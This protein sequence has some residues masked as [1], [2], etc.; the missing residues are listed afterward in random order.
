MPD[1]EDRSLI[2]VAGGSLSNAAGSKGIMSA[3][4][5]ETLAITREALAM[6]ARRFKIGRYEWCEPEYRQILIWAKD[7]GMEPETLVERL[8]YDE[9]KSESAFANFL[10]PPRGSMVRVDNGKI[11]A[12]DWCL[13]IRKLDLSSLPHLTALGWWGLGL[14]ELRLTGVPKLQSLHFNSGE[15]PGPSD[16]AMLDLSLVPNLLHL[17]CSRTGILSLDLSGVAQLVSLGCSSTP[18]R[19]LELSAVPKLQELNCGFTKIETLDLSRV[20]DLRKLDCS[21]TGITEL[22]LRCVPNLT[23]LTYGG[24]SS[25][26][27]GIRDLA[28]HGVPLLESLICSGSQIDALDLSVAPNL[29]YLDCSNTTIRA[30][31]LSHAPQLAVLC[32]LNTQIAK[33]EFPPGSQLAELICMNTNISSLDVTGLPN[34]KFLYCSSTKILELDIRALNH[35]GHVVYDAGTT[36]LIQREDQHF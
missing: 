23:H 11:V 21:N 36:R 9:S 31:D 24:S 5:G 6:E 8:L 16:F 28:L 14:V 17:G 4:V 33:L 29:R 10:H 12:L 19:S 25:A 35:L 22:D 26:K 34:L 13:R 27:A 20:P 32:C 7:L 2:P 15:V 18:L 3:M 30:L 1:S